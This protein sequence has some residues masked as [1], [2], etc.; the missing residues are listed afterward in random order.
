MAH[1]KKRIV[2]LLCTLQLVSIDALAQSGEWRRHLLSGKGIE[3]R[4]EFSIALPTVPAL[5]DY[6]IDVAA[7]LN[8]SA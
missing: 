6:S 7:F 3:L 8:R 2:F 1:L 4:E 5:V